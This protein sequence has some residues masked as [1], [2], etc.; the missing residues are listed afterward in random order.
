MRK[1]FILVV[2]A[3]AFFASAAHAQVGDWHQVQK[4]PAGAP[5]TV[6]TRN[7][8][9]CRFEHATDEKL[10]CE[11]VLR[12]R[13]LSTSRQMAFD[14][15]RVQQVSL[16]IM[17]ER[18]GAIGAAVGAGVGAASLAAVDKPQDS[19]YSRGGSALL[20]GAF[21]GLVGYVIAKGTPRMEHKVVY[22][23]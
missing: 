22:Q 8:L 3:V 12:G 11:F 7:R 18:N 6:Q 9:D 13:F 20:G 14:R 2:L 1:A 10:F 15:R 21:G 4:L 19:G 5:I 17:R 16:D 23:R